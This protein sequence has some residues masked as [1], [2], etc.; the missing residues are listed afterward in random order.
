MRGPERT[1]KPRKTGIFEHRTR[2]G[3][4]FLALRRE[5]PA[6]M[7]EGRYLTFGVSLAFVGE[8]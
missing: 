2:E 3:T 5:D 1:G 7:T 6:L 4:I 8:D